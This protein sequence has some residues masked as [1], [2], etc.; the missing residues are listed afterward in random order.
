MQ[1]TGGGALSIEPKYNL[2]DPASVMCWRTRRREEGKGTH[3]EKSNRPLVTSVLFSPLGPYVWLDG[4]RSKAGA[5]VYY[6]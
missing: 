2:S 5:T 3:S 1:K 6:G 4:L